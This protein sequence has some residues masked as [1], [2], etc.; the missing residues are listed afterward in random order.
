MSCVTCQASNF[1]CHMSGQGSFVI[2]QVSG[3]M[4]H[5]S[6]DREGKRVSNIPPTSHVSCVFCWVCCVRCQV[7]VSRVTYQVCHISS[8]M[9]HVS[10]VTVHGSQVMFS[11][12]LSHEDPKLC[13][14][15]ACADYSTCRLSR[16]VLVNFVQDPYWRCYH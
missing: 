15:C 4:C 9:C 1:R 12:F 13:K 6:Q 14:I 10:H 5:L 16:W 2:C 3:V 8:V 7:Q 11:F